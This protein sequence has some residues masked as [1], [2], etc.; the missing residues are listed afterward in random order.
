MII[1]CEE[2]KKQVINEIKQLIYAVDNINVI[3][4]QILI[5]DIVSQIFEILLRDNV[6]HWMLK[7]HN[8]FRTATKKR[9][10]DAF[11]LREKFEY[12]HDY[13]ISEHHIF[14]ISE[15]LGNFILNL[16]KENEVIYQL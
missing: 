14:K 1:I 9:I 13:S 12:K 6:G 5:L 16:E 4:N 7:S 11:E 10:I 8:G 3:H 2:E 15:D